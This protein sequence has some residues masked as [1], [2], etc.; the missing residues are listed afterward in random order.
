MKNKTEFKTLN[1]FE[2]HG[3]KT[4]LKKAFGDLSNLTMGTS[5]NGLINLENNYTDNHPNDKF[6]YLGAFGLTHGHDVA[7]EYWNDEGED[8]KT[9]W[10]TYRNL[11]NFENEEN[12]NELL[13]KI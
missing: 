11:A 8:S 10:I 3:L 13:N 2:V 12:F 7:L 6:C 1:Q 9:Y 5:Q 4:L